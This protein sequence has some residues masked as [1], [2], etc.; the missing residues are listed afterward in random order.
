VTFGLPGWYAASPRRSMAVGNDFKLLRV[1]VVYLAAARARLRSRC[2]GAIFASSLR[3]YEDIER[4]P[5]RG[6]QSG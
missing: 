6:Y 5:Q 2:L 1:M 4:P 3:L